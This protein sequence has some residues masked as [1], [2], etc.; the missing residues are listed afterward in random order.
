MGIAATTVPTPIRPSNGAIGRPGNG[1]VRV[2][3][4]PTS[5]NGMP[6]KP[7]GVQSSTSEARVLTPCSRPHHEANNFEHFYDTLR[8]ECR[9]VGH[10][11]RGGVAE[12]SVGGSPKHFYHIASRPL[13]QERV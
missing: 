5:R 6:V 9:G 13:S 2:A 7:C 10:E 8:W 12:N 1:L 11:A 3:S 4:L